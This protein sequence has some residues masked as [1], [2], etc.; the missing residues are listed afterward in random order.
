MAI[1]PCIH[2]VLFLR[3][4]PEVVSW[5]P[6]QSLLRP[7]ETAQ[8]VSTRS[9]STLAGILYQPDGVQGVASRVLFLHPRSPERFYRPTTMSQDIPTCVRLGMVTQ[10]RT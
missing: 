8:R 10:I 3:V 1:W 2:R 7:R 4:V 9:T 6:Q 5:P